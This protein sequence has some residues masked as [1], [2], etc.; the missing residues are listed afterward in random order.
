MDSGETTWT[1]G[2]I[3]QRFALELHGEDRPISGVCG[4]TDDEPGRLSYLRSGELLDAAAASSIPAFVTPRGMAVPGKTSLFADDPE[5]SIAAIAELF[6]RE[7][8]CQDEDIH[9]GAVVAADARIGPGCHIG[10]RAVIGTGCAIGPGCRIHAGAVIHDRVRIGRDCVL[11][12]NVVVREDCHLGDRVIVQPGAVIG[13]DGYGYVTRGHRHRKIP[14]LGGVDIGDDVEIGANTTIDR[15]RFSAT[16]IGRGTKVDN[17]VMIGHNCRIG[18]DCLI[19]SQ[20]GISGSTEI[21]DRVVLAGQVGVGGHLSIAADVTVL[22]MGM[23]AGDIREA[24][25]YAGHPVRPAALWRRAVARFYREA[26]RR[27]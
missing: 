10:P 1:L 27:H 9:P 18:E 12:A 26:R 19:V 17:L 24:G 16:R 4:L 25:I 20:V 11:H 14:Q 3:A 8:A 23:V 21:G 22:G 6:V 7:P 2:A 5:L 13:G 15:G